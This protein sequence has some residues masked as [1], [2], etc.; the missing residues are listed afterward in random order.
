MAAVYLESAKALGGGGVLPVSSSF[1][2][3][4]DSQD[5]WLP[6]S[7]VCLHLHMASPPCLCL[8]ASYYLFS[9]FRAAYGAYGGSQARVRIGATAA[10][11]PHS[12]SN[13]GSKLRL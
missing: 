5:L 8:P 2:G 10:C 6:P 7:H 1:C 11:L 4:P 3:A 12:R 9:L 13:V